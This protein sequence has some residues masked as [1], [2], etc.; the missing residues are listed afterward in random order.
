VT[1]PTVPSSAV[2]IDLA[3]RLRLIVTRLH[4]R[5]RQQSTT[6]I[7]PSQLSALSSIDR[8]GPVTLGDL[9]LIEQV[10]PPTMTRIVSA[11]EESGLVSREIDRL[12]RR[13]A[14]VRLSAEG[15][16]LLQK[17][18]TRKNAY[19]A[20]Q[21]RTLA[22]EERQVLESAAPILERWLEEAP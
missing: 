18:R 21:L 20:R 6:G 8:M 7:S 5:L 15:R 14:R 11:L 13:V 1:V 4:R 9:A 10:Q 12:D 2:E 17:I 16:R 3:A 19:V 22:P